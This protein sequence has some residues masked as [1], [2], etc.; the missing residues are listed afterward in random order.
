MRQNIISFREFVK[1]ADSDPARHFA[2]VKRLHEEEPERFAALIEHVRR[3]LSR[4]S[5]VTRRP[6]SRAHVRALLT[7]D[8]A[9][10]KNHSQKMKKRR[11][12]RTTKATTR[13]SNS[14]ARSG[15]VPSRT[16]RETS[17]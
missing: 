4:L 1:L 6:H 9:W 16:W 5:S 15:P 10:L 13:A 17:E 11:T 7:G 2:E 12:A 3:G 8:V 14:T